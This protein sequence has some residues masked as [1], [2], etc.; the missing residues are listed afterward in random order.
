MGADGKDPTGAER[1]RAFLKIFEDHKKAAERNGRINEQI[2]RTTEKAE[3]NIV[4]ALDNLAGEVAALNETLEAH[5]DALQAH[6]EASG[7]KVDL[8]SILSGARARRRK[9]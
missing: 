9:T 8:G 4:A 6:A 5:G 2:I 7:L 3:R 1:F